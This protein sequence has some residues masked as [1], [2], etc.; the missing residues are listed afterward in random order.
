MIALA[1]LKIDED[2]V[3]APE[4][5]RLAEAQPR[6]K[7]SAE[8]EA[9]QRLAPEQGNPPAPVALAASASP[10][11]SAV[12]PAA[13]AVGAAIGWI[14]LDVSAANHLASIGSSPQSMAAALDTSAAN[15]MS[16]VSVVAGAAAVTRMVPGDVTGPGNACFPWYSI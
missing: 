10:T 7:E 1:K 8:L 15:H 14:D 6:V 11:V 5:A 4:E 12:N 3:R 13:S 9:E 16:L 2:K